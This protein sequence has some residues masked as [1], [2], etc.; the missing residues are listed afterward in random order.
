MKYIAWLDTETT[1]LEPHKGKLLEVACVVTDLALKELGEFHRIASYSEETLAMFCD[2]VVT[3]MHKGNGLWEACTKSVNLTQTIEHELIHF[4]HE[5]TDN[6]GQYDIVLAGNTIGFD[7]GFL[8]A[9]TPL[10]LAHVH[11]RMLDVTA[12]SYGMIPIVGVELKFDKKKHHRALDDVRESIAQYKAI[13]KQF[14]QWRE[15]GGEPL[16]DF[17]LGAE[18]G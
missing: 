11:Y 13:W 10:V 18:E 5:K 9:H 6:A 1:G 14:F 15:R 3:R 17:G 4:L 16:L 2:D 8:A 12:V 7:R